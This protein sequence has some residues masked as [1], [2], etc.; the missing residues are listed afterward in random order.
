MSNAVRRLTVAG[1]V[2]GV[3]FRP[4][5]YRL[6][7]EFELAGWVL[8]AAG[9]VE[10]EIQGPAA[11]LDAFARALV[12]RAPPLA[13]PEL[14]AETATGP[15]KKFEP[16]DGFEIRASQAG[17][18]PEIH[19]PPDQFLCDDCLAE[20]SA[21]DERRYRYPFIN[22]TQCGPRY[23]IIRALPYDRPNTTLKDFPLCRACEA[24]YTDP[25]DRRFH[26]QPLACPAC[27]P[28]LAFRRGDARLDEDEAALAAAV[29][30]LDAGEILAVRGVGGYHLVCDAANADAVAGLRRRKQRPHKPLAVMVP[31]RGDDGLDAARALAELDPAVADRLGDPERPIALARL[32][33]GHRL[34]DGVA[35]GL[36][37]V[38]LMLPYSPLHH[39]LLSALARPV[40]A[41]SGN[42][43]G[44]PVLTE[45]AQAEARLSNIADAFLHHNRPIQRPA[46]DPVWRLN[47]G[48]MRPIRLGRGNAPL[49]LE[50]P[51]ALE[52]PILA[53]GAFLKNTVALGW[54]RRAVVSPHIGELDSP[55]AVEVFAQV[56]EDLQALY[57]VRAEWLACDAHPDFPN[58]RW[59]RDTGLPLTRI[60]HHEAHAAALA[61]EFDRVGADTLVLTWDGVG[62]GRDGTL[63]GGE[64]LYGRP[65][66]WRRVASLKPFRLPGGDRVIRQ[67]WR[68]ALS[69]S[70]HAGFEWP[71]APDAD[72]LLKHAW[73]SGLASPWTSAAGRLFDGAAALAGVALEASYEG[74]GPTW[75]EALAHRGHRGH[76]G[77][78]GAAA[79]PPVPL[80]V[81]DESGLPRADWGPL[82]AWMAD[83]STAPADR[84]AGFHGAM[85]ELAGSI[86]DAVA[87]VH[88]VSAVGLTG[89]VFQNALLSRLVIAQIRQRG[90]EPLLPAAIPVN[91]AGIS[92]GQVIEATARQP[93]DRPDDQK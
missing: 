85:A 3:G 76:R 40:I 82:M 42:L 45:P 64:A 70:W 21:P 2:Q 84:A 79:K 16:L 10:I 6:A 37:E 13:R 26:A 1:R 17:A 78:S 15:T 5:V 9:V 73:E 68:T 91:D 62:Y 24:E 60:F 30:A 77:N 88:P 75:L 49:E 92:Y 32:K 25:L 66:N 47:S 41:T 87:A 11:S 28:S 69:L 71:E 55:R 72:P 31:M 65:G 74:Q 27:G 19:V 20:M 51:V 83:R 44:E 50:L 81:S 36:N 86:V 8:N 52:R 14:V 4:F 90:I 67:P 59:A 38:G 22:C 93:T 56:V 35:P 46:D 12:E 89:G 33:P 61:G 23:T 34:A 43:S 39:L 80:L 54:N 57:G 48:R 29:A 18:E 63:W 53:V 58:S 7:H